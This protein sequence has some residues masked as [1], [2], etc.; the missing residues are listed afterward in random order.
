MLFTPVVRFES[1]H[2]PLAGL[3]PFNRPSELWVLIP[4]MLAIQ[5]IYPETIYQVWR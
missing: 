3:E 2:V 5:M 4:P 1:S